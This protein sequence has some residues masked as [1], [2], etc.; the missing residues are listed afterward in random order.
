MGGEFWRTKTQTQK[1]MI[2]EYFKKEQEVAENTALRNEIS[3]CIKWIQGVF[4]GILKPAK[5]YPKL[6]WGVVKLT[7]TIYC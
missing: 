3:P 6:D 4:Q 2:L 1:P 7:G 5:T